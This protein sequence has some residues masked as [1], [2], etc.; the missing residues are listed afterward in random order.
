MAGHHAL[1]PLSPVLSRSPAAPRSVH[2]AARGLVLVL[3]YCLGL[4]LPFVLLAIGSSWAVNTAG[5]LRHRTRAIQLTGGALLLIVG[6]LLVT[7]PWGQLVTPL[8]NPISGFTT[9]L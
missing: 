4:G 1:D 3:A 5:W 6:A 8:R 7:G 9:P 2:T